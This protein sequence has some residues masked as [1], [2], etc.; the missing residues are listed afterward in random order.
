MLT[1]F[2]VIVVGGGDGPR[3]CD[4]WLTSTAPKINTVSAMRLDT[5]DITDTVITQT[6]R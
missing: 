3:E 5:D 4:A 2:G 1:V 6:G